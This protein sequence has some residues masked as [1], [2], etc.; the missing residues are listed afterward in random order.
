MAKKFKIAQSATFKQEVDVPRIGGESV[1]IKFEYKYLTRKELAKIYDKWREAAE[2]LNVDQ[3]MSYEELV[4]LEVGLQV[5]QL[6][7]ILVGWEFEDEFNEDA[8]REL[9]ESSTHASQEIINKYHEAYAQ[10]KLG[11]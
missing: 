4:D 1:K 3:D 10:V 7:D 6:K 5:E 2:S 11:N 9:V 8:I